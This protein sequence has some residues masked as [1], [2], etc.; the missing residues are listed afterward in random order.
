MWLH[1]CCYIVSIWSITSV[2]PISFTNTI[3]SIIKFFSH[4]DQFSSMTIILSMQGTMQLSFRIISCKILCSWPFVMHMAH[5]NP[6]NSFIAE[7]VSCFV[8]LTYLLDNLS[9]FLFSPFPIFLTSKFFFPFSFGSFSWQKLTFWG[10][11]KLNSVSGHFG[12]KN[13][14]NPT[15]TR[16]GSCCSLLPHFSWYR[17]T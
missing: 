3:S 12:A 1:K 2:W 13:Q 10:G 9:P 16:G 14:E 17:Y 4:L 11:K 7:M 6:F 8:Q 5:C 15:T